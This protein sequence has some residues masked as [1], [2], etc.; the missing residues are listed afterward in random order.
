VNFKH[1]VEILFDVAGASSV[2]ARVTD[3]KYRTSAAQESPLA[4]LKFVNDF[5]ESVG[6][7]SLVAMNA[8]KDNKVSTWLSGFELV[9]LDVHGHLLG[10]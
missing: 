9:S 7:T 8:A 5:S 1:P 6:A 2:S 4:A 10:D 3:W